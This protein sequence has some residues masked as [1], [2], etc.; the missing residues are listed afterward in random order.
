MD[1]FDIVMNKVLNKKYN[2]KKKNTLKL[3]KI[4]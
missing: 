1:R 2:C 3:P 4:L